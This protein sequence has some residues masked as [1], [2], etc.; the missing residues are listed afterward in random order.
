MSLGFSWFFFFTFS[1]NI[2]KLYQNKPVRKSSENRH[3]FE[4]ELS[5]RLSRLQDI[6]HQEDISCWNKVIIVVIWEA[7]KEIRRIR[8]RAKLQK[9]VKFDEETSGNKGN[10]AYRRFNIQ[11][12]MKP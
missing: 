12:W 1:V 8:K 5:N 9:K 7:A 4:F 3:T 2:S 10:T 6:A 11:W